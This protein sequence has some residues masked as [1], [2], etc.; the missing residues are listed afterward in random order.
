[1]L[2]YGTIIPT[3]LNDVARN[4]ALQHQ[5]AVDRDGLK[6][7]GVVHIEQDYVTTVR[8]RS[9]QASGNL[10]RFEELIPDEDTIVQMFKPNAELGFYSYDCIEELPDGRG[11][12][13]LVASPDEGVDSHKYDTLPEYSGIEIIQTDQGRGL[14]IEFRM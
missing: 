10:A 1:M 8:N 5:V 9:I 12:Y 11:V 13:R 3:A 2:T 7:P 4:R 14:I 6:K